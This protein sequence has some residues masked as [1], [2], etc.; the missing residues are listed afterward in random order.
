MKVR[1]RVVPL[2]SFVHGSINADEGTPFDCE[3]GLAEELER[4]SLV[5]IKNEPVPAAPSADAPK[6]AAN[7]GGE[8]GK[9]QDDGAGPLSSASPVAPASPTTMS[10][11]SAR[12]RSRN[13]TGAE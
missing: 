8:P 3:K 5:R 11:S 13:R 1:V 12:G 6:D 10:K 9:A 7:A 2:T 4:A